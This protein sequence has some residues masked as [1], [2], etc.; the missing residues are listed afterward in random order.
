MVPRKLEM[1]GDVGD[2]R[3]IFIPAFLPLMD[4]NK[5]ISKMK[6]LLDLGINERLLI[7]NILFFFFC[8]ARDGTQNLINARQDSDPKLHPQLH[9]IFW[10]LMVSGCI[11]LSCLA[12][13][14][15]RL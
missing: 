11:L 1:A 2:R 3:W 12:L 10:G 7:S 14:C 5:R 6:T 4:L 15:G 8:D 9:A 13:I